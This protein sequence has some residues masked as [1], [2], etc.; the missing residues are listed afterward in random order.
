MLT[1]SDLEI[2]RLLN[3]GQEVIVKFKAELLVSGRYE[4]FQNNVNL[5]RS[6]RGITL[7]ELAT[8]IEDETGNLSKIL[9][10]KNKK[11]FERVPLEFFDK[12]A[13]TLGVQTQ[14]LLY[15]DLQ[16]NFFDMIERF[17]KS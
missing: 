6:I 5:L 8:R 12:I 15:V 4:I 9:S 1:K 3:K 16:K 13:E 2:L 10:G 14:T 11:R 17:E 7:A